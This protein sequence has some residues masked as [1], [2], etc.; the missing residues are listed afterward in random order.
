MSYSINPAEVSTTPAVSDARL[1]PS[2]KAE[3]TVRKRAVSQSQNDTVQVSQ[4][5]QAKS[6]AE[7]GESVSQIAANMGIPTDTV[8]TLLGVTEDA[9]TAA[10]AA[11]AAAA[12]SATRTLSAMA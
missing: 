7:Q 1:D 4:A 9:T 2:A 12:A 3:D 8:K 11:V 6:M 5:A 10:L